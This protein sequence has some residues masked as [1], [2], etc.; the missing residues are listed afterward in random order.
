M[1]LKWITGL[2]VGVI[3]ATNYRIIIGVTLRYVTYWFRLFFPGLSGS[4]A[5]DQMVYWRQAV[6]LETTKM[7]CFAFQDVAFAVAW[8]K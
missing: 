1:D 7:H 3:T 4:K 6:T 5:P 2:D 8:L